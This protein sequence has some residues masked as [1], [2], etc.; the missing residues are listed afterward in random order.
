NRQR[1]R[2][3]LRHRRGRATGLQLERGCGVILGHR[4]PHERRLGVMAEQKRSEPE[5]ELVATARR[6]LP[7]GGFGNVPH[8]IVIADGRGS[9]VWDVSGNEYVDYLLGSGPM[10]VGHAHPE[11]VE[12]VQ[13]VAA[14]GTTFFAN[15]EHG[16][17]LA[18]EIVDAVPCAEQV[19]FVST[20]SE[21]DAYAMRLARAFKKSDKIMKFQGGYHGMSDYSLMS[22][23]PKRPGNFPQ[24]VPDSAGIPRSVQSEVIV[25]P[26]NDAA[27]AASIIRE[28]AHELG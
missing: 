11:V 13:Q 7:G 19:R 10:I 2:R 8:E 12:V 24:G 21:A 1:H 27:S 25:A 4:Q 3:R 28:H 5:A 26:F 9:H 22:L 23:A 14:K 18:A 20:G 6:V 17:R 15:N 16:I